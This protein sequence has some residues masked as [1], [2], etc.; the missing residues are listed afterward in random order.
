MYNNIYNII[1]YVII[2]CDFEKKKFPLK[3]NIIFFSN[4]YV[5]S[6]LEIFVNLE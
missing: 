5:D 6:I 1:I 4:G 2:T 3:F